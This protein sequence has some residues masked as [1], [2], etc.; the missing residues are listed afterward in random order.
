MRTYKRKTNR[1]STS[2]D[3]IDRA[4]QQ[5]I[6]DKKSINS[7]A[8][9]FAIPYKTLQRHVVNMTKKIEKNPELSKSE[10]TLDSVGYKR[11]R[12]IFSDEEELALESYLKKAADIYY[13][14]T[15][16]ETR[17]FAYEFAKKK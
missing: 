14:L 7:T 6:F 17:K 1:G 2:K 15:P 4:C 11:N 5:V 8:K 12:Q 10:S 3:V 16:Y 13:G 9:Q